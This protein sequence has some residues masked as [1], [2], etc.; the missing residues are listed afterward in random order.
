ML[1]QAVN[2]G[3]RLAL[4][5][6][7]DPKMLT[8]DV[9]ELMGNVGK[10]TD[11]LG[12]VKVEIREARADPSSTI[13]EIEDSYATIALSHQPQKSMSSTRVLTND[14]DPRWNET[15]YVL[16]NRGK[17]SRIPQVSRYI[18]SCSI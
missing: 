12:V 15:L 4:A 14:K 18:R 5:D 13:Q 1:K 6:M 7:V 16:L 10:D 2:E 17:M 9:R 11:A 3:V 8:L